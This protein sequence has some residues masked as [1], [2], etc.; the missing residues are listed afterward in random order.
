[1]LNF[2]SVISG[3]YEISGIYK[4]AYELLLYKTQFSCT[5]IRVGI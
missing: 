4:L 1:M 2:K 3:L 5:F